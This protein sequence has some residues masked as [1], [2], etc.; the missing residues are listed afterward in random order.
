MALQRQCHCTLS[1]AGIG[2]D[3]V[4]QSRQAVVSLRPRRVDQR[5]AIIDA[6]GTRTLTGLR[7][8]KRDKRRACTL[9][10]RPHQSP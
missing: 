1:S 10:L 3:V 2:I 9:R 4:K 8:S 5:V 7:G 6:Q